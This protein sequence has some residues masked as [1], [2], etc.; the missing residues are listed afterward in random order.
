MLSYEELLGAPERRLQRLMS[1]LGLSFEAQQLEYWR[2]RQYGTRKTQWT[3]DR[4]TD[5]YR[6][7]L[8][9]QE[10]LSPE[11]AGNVIRRSELRDYAASQGYRFGAE[12]L[13]L[14]QDVERSTV[15]PEPE[16]NLPRPWRNAVSSDHGD[17]GG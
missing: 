7:D 17:R 6:P 8:R 10:A 16:T 9:W 11:D 1:E 13:E 15:P 2:A 3:A 4:P 12:G 5:P 14:L